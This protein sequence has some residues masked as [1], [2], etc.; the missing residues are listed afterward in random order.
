MNNNKNCCCSVTKSCSLF[1]TPWTRADQA[2]LSSTISQN[3]LKLMSI[4]LVILSDH[5]ILSSA[6]PFSFCLQ[7]FPASGS[8]PVSQFFTSGGQSIGSSASATVLPMNI[9]DWFLLGW[10]GWI[11]LQ[12]K[13]LSR[14]LSNTTIKR[15]GSLA[16]SFLCGSTVT[17][18]HD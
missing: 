10:T 8:F 6:T 3:L 12:S 11:S 17:S 16:F 18:I 7:S 14:V 15:T 5:L 4:E 1:V 9:Q 2:L 13:G